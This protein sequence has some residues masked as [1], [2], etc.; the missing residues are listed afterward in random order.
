MN[1]REV[2]MKNI[3]AAVISGFGDEWRRF[4]QSQLSKDEQLRLFD[5]Y[6]S[7][8]PWSKLPE[9]A[10]GFDAGCGS[11]RWAEVCAD[12]VGHLSLIDASPEALQVA[13]RKLSKCG[14][15]SFHLASVA[16]I[17]LPEGSQDFG[18][19]LGVLHHVPDTR[20]ALR[21]C[22]TRLKIGAP[23]LVYLYYKFD[24]RPLWFRAVWKA[25]DILRTLVSRLP[26]SLRY[27]V[28]QVI[29]AIIYWPIA[30]TAAIME[31]FDVDVSNVPLSS[32]RDKSYYTMRT[33]ALDRFGTR[34]EHRFTR[35]EISQLMADAGLDD[36]SFRDGVPYWCAVGYRQN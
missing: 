5:S 6:F 8:F 13:K 28:S 14:N 29:A 27:A 33:D 24:N 3:N 30:R 12:R 9:N 11:G 23:F 17:P 31:K 26:N 36:I 1:I 2:L 19:S 4:D 21:S 18:Y 7:V 35:E 16:E 34:L 10:I 25:S 20:S 22:V 32:Y 15:V